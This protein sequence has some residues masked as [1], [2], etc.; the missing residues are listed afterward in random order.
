VWLVHRAIGR[1]AL[2]RL[3]F[4]FQDGMVLATTLRGLDAID[5]LERSL[6]RSETLDRL[7]PDLGDTGLAHVRA[8]P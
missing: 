5:L 1:E 7:C 2:R 6:A 3:A 4:L 8:L